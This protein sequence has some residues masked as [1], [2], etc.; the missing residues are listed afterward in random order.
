MINSKIFITLIFFLFIYSNVFAQTSKKIVVED[1]DKPKLQKLIKDR[2]GKIL[3]LNIWASWCAPCKKEFPDLVKLA[4]KYK[5]SKVEIVGLSVDDREDLN[6]AVIPFL[7]QNN[8][9]F[10]I[11]LQNFKNIEEL[12]E[13]FP[14]WQGAIPLTVIFDAKGNQKKFIV[15]MRDF[16]FFDNAIQEVLKPS[17]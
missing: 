10:K 11:Y 15:G 6:S 12:I 5:K 2:K 17:K 7:Q 1:I 8:V 13:F 16:T 9:N 3:F 14:Q 4:E